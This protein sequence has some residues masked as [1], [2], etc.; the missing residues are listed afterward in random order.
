MS[1]PRSLKG[2]CFFWVIKASV[3]EIQTIDT[4]DLS[5]I[6]LDFFWLHRTSVVLQS[7]SSKILLGL[8]S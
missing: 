5:I 6:S 4:N 1:I 7:N 2:I 8:I 3:P